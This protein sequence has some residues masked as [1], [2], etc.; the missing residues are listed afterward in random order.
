MP[1]TSS[2]IHR[3]VLIKQIQLHTQ[4]TKSTNRATM[5]KPSVPLPTVLLQTEAA[6]LFVFAVTSA[7]SPPP[8]PPPP[9]PPAT[10]SCRPSHPYLYRPKIEKLKKNKKK[11][12]QIT[13]TKRCP[14]TSCASPHKSETSVDFCALPGYRGCYPCPLT[15]RASGPN[16]DDLTCVSQTLANPRHPSARL[17]KL[18]PSNPPPPPPPQPGPSH[19]RSPALDEDIAFHPPWNTHAAELSTTLGEIEGV[20]RNQQKNEKKR[21]PWFKTIAFLDVVLC[22]RAYRLRLQ[23]VPKVLESSTPTSTPFFFFFF[24]CVPS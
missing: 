4:T 17:M 24:F 20:G 8:T 19:L 7:P 2:A 9:P 12:S 10:Q 5:T 22:E 18:S 3:L 23:K 13:D 16:E 15:L 1:K 14:S 21:F 11:N 6:R